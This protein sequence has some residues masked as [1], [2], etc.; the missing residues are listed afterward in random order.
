M[1][2]GTYSTG[3][4]TLSNCNSCVVLTAA[5]AICWSPENVCMLNKKCG[6]F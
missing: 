3:K 6:C 1:S 4:I 2:T 5:D